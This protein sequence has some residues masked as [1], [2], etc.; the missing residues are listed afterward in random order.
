MRYSIET[1]IEQLTKKPGV[2]ETLIHITMTWGVPPTVVTLTLARVCVVE[3][4]VLINITHTVVL[5]RVF[6]N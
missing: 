4:G 3:V 2:V 5:P 6:N 1:L